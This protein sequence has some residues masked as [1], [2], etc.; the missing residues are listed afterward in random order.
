MHNYIISHM[1]IRIEKYVSTL[2]LCNDTNALHT[3]AHKLDA[4]GKK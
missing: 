4:V 1:C 2:A 3:P